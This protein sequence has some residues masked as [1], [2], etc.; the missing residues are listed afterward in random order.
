MLFFA[1]HSKLWRSGDFEHRKLVLR[2]AFSDRIPYDRDGGFRTPKTSFPFKVL[3]GLRT[4]RS[5]MARPKRFELLTHRC[6]LLYPAELGGGIP[7]NWIPAVF[8]TAPPLLVG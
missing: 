3:E 1:S 2:L 7:E 4:G 6:L 5:E 8:I